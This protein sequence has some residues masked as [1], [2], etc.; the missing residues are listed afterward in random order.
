MTKGARMRRRLGKPGACNEV[1]AS[2][3][4]RSYNYGKYEGQKD[5]KDHSGHGKRPAAH[6]LARAWG[7]NA[8]PGGANCGPGVVGHFR[9]PS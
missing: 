3:P 8:V 9:S 6:E 4:G 2:G 5:T 1:T 7:F